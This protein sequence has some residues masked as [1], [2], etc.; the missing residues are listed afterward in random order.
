MNSNF[1]LKRTPK[2]ITQALLIISLTLFAMFCVYS[3]EYTIS[4]DDDT[5]LLQ[6]I[7][8][9]FFT[10][11]VVAK[12]I[13][14]K[15]IEDTLCVFFVREGYEGHYGVAQLQQGI[16][17][18]YRFTDGYLSNNGLYSINTVNN[19]RKGN[20]YYLL[21]G[22]YD[23]PNVN[24]FELI[25]AENQSELYTG[26]VLQAPFMEIIQIADLTEDTVSNEINYYDVEGTK[27]NKEELWNSLPK[28]AEGSGLGVS[29]AELFLVN[30][31]LGII[32][33]VGM[34]IATGVLFARKENRIEKETTNMI[35]N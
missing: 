21:T 19:L 13:D 23:L 22:L 34:I 12:I 29:T 18:K 15:L 4:V 6:A 10:E 8:E 31:I 5:V 24:Y 35:C 17:G 30:I 7:D 26:T 9:Y 33:S 25:S 28:P 11:S 32:F 20:G 16:L 2:Q 27:L 1:I 3:S 14:K